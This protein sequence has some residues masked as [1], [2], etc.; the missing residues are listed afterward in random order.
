MSSAEDIRESG[1]YAQWTKGTVMV[2]IRHAERCDR[3][4]NAC[5]DDPAGITV[6]GSQVA[7]EVG[8]GIA[9]LGLE[10]AELLSS[11]EVRT[12]QTSH[13]IFGRPIATQDW[14][15]QC[16]E[17][18]ADAALGHK[19]SGRNLVLIT[20]SGCIDQLERHLK[21]AGGERSSA[22]ASTLFISVPDKG[23]ARILGQMDASAWNHLVSSV[24][25]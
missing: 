20:H 5:L 17:G 3:S 24:G 7:A 11:P 9:R 6:A 21:V 13:F 19:N 10:N 25:L 8:K 4:H 2:L 15:K 22:Y 16:D 18:F 12:R 23:K 1:I 14:L